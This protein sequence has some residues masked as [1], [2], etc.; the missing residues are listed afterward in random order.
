[1]KI[2]RICQGINDYD[3]EYN[4]TLDQYTING[5]YILYKETQ[6]FSSDICVYVG[7][8]NIKNRLK[9]HAKEKDFDYAIVH[10]IENDKKRKYVEAVLIECLKPTLNKAKPHPENIIPTND[11]DKLSHIYTDICY[12][13]KYLEDSYSEIIYS[14][15]EQLNFHKEKSRLLEN[16]IVEERKQRTIDNIYQSI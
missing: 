7:Q 12:L 8:G 11:S 9:T 16:K 5:V 3:I 2:K 10:D 14:L 15:K 1:M 6:K 13:R 4:L